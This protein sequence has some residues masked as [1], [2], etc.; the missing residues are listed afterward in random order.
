MKAWIPRD[1][2]I[3]LLFDDGVPSRGHRRN[4]PNPAYQ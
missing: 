4:M 1:V 2:V 3:D